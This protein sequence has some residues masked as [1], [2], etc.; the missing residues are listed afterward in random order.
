MVKKKKTV[1]MGP[2]NGNIFAVMGACSKALKKDGRKAD[3]D[4]L[5]D[6]VMASGSYE[7]A[8]TICGK[9]VEFDID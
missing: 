9:Y 5:V 7:E 6:E 3:A 2:I 1:V 4:K 8:L